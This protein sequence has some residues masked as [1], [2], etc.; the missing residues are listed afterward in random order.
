MPFEVIVADRPDGRALPAVLN[1]AVQEARGQILVF[2]SADLRLE[3]WPSVLKD[4]VIAGAVTLSGKVI[5]AGAEVTQNGS[6]QRLHW[7]LNA[8]EPPVRFR[9]PVMA[10]CPQLLVITKTAFDDLKGFDP[11]FENGYVQELCLRIRDAGVTVMFDPGLRAVATGH[12]RL[13]RATAHQD[14]PE[15]ARRSKALAAPGRPLREHDGLRVLFVEDRVPHPHLGRG[16]P[17]SHAL[18]TSLCAHGHQVTLY[19]R[20]FPREDWHEIYSDIPDTVR[21]ERLS[22]RFGLRSFLR[23]NE[24]AFD[25]AI[26]SRPHNM[27]AY[28]LAGGLHG[29]TPVLYDAEALFCLRD[30]ELQKVHGHPL[31]PQQED[32]LVRAEVG[33]AR[34]VSAVFC[35]SKS[36]ADHFRQG[37]IADVHILRHIVSASSDTPD[38]RDRT[39]ILFI[40]PMDNPLSPNADGVQWFASEVLPRLRHILN[41]DVTLL[42]VGDPPPASL[43]RE[44]SDRV[45]FLGLVDDLAPLYR[46]A[47]AFVAP[48][49]FSAGIPLKVCEAAAA[50]VPVATT[51]LA[52][53]QLGWT[54]G[55]D[56][57][58]GGS[59]E[60]LARACAALLVDD[61]LWIRVR[62]SALERV[63][64][65]CSA[66]AFEDTLEKALQAAAKAPPVH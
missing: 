20:L 60:E 27:R 22:G 32:T 25:A 4:S 45:L 58:V 65:E 55:A 62:A 51:P 26:V 23:R 29:R 61:E 31:S 15:L 52:A 5:S 63:R 34:G 18:L 53:R 39:E 1:R 35:V 44:L 37:G 56:L 50:G 3:G 9:H 66:E 49:R 40:G 57:V 13:W 10:A 43:A 17:R 11:T 38:L 48:V 42:A 47:R 30:I 21:V 2:M 12:A 8:D 24:A 41:K 64:S 28:R 59:P 7:G 54:D 16:L 19:P 33:L 6:T 46:T 14:A 36:E